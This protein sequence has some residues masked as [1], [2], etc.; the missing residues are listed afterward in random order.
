MAPPRQATHILLKDKEILSSFACHCD[1]MAHQQPGR[2]GIPASR[3]MRQVTVPL[4]RQAQRVAMPGAPKMPQIPDPPWGT[5][6]L[7]CAGP[8][9]CRPTAG[10][11]AGIAL[12]R[13]EQAVPTDGGRSRRSRPMA[14]GAGG[15][16]R[17]RAEPQVSPDR[18]RSKPRC[19]LSNEV[20]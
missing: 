14:S 12:W 18:E 9:R 6:P 11:A 7:I 2:A 20:L 4:R 19:P 1:L 5:S 15:I 16:A 13:A 3:R 17:W 8:R 10:G